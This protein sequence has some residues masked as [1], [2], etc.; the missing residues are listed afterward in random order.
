MTILER[1]E[2][3][4]DYAGTAYDPWDKEKIYKYAKKIAKATTWQDAGL[5]LGHL[6]HKD[7]KKDWCKT[8]GEDKFEFIA[9]VYAIGM[10]FLVLHPII[11]SNG[12]NDYLIS[13]GGWVYVLQFLFDIAPKSSYSNLYVNEHCL[14]KVH[15]K[16]IPFEQLPL[17][18]SWSWTPA[19]KNIL[20]DPTMLRSPIFRPD[21]TTEWMLAKRAVKDD[22][23]DHLSKSRF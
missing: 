21:V 8:H 5:V 11:M 4:G 16:P 18:M 22:A 17:Y 10:D 19:A 23:Y 2:K 9:K 3:A 14:G 1:I 20:A 13:I 7:A 12:L 15:L 6:F